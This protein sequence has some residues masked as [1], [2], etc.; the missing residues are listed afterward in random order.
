VPAFKRR[1]AS[2]TIK[3][4]FARVLP[5]E[6]LF[7]VLFSVAGVLC[8]PTAPAA[9]QTPSQDRAHQP[10]QVA[11]GRADSVQP[12]REESLR[13][14]V[15]E[16][17]S[18]LQLGRWDQAEAY[19][20]VE[21]RENFRRQQKSLFLGF[22]VDSIKLDPDGK[23]AIV[24]LQVQQVMGQGPPTPITAPQTTRWVFADNLWYLVVPDPANQDKEFHALFDKP[25]GRAP[26]SLR[27]EELKFKGH[28]YIMGKIQP[29]QIKVA[30]FP[31]TNVTDHPVSISSVETGCPCLEAKVEKKEFKPGESGEIA[32]TFNPAGYERE[33]VETVVVKTDPGDSTTYLTVTGYIIPR[34][35]QGRKPAAKGKPGS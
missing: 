18:L 35:L 22:K 2:L 16:L 13:K 19:I 15:A 23:E 4:R 5:R 24:R 33:Y 6:V 14:R 27:P 12:G 20:T 32:I 1:E 17:Y 26:A 11:A 8:L 10:K 29:G 21:S 3:Q 7:L 9:F 25:G 28:R 34:E 31:F 30:R